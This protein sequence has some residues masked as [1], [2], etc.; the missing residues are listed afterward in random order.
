MS[1]I[2]K[3]FDEIEKNYPYW[4]SWVQFCYLVNEYKLDKKQIDY[5]FKKYVDP[6]DYQGM[7]TKD[8]LKHFYNLCQS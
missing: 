5:Y 1:K 6:N 3:K 8:A 4:S 2:S 7:S